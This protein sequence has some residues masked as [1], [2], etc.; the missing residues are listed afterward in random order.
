[1]YPIFLLGTHHTY[2]ALGLS[3]FVLV[4]ALIG[5]GFYRTGLFLL[6]M[7]PAVHPSVGVWV[8]AVA[9][10]AFVWDFRRL[11]E[12]FRPALKYFV[13]GCAVTVL[14]LLVQYTFIYH[15]THA[16]PAA[17]ARTFSTFVN[18]WDYHRRAAAGTASA[19]GPG[20]SR[21]GRYR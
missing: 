11:R 5:A 18:V 10:I 19:R 20:L 8:G 6:G 9:A 2:G 16:D 7:A 3:L 4:V 12:E 1:M 13:A 14:S 21:F 15:R 17:V